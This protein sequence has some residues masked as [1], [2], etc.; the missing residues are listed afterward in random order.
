M[1]TIERH[2]HEHCAEPVDGRERSEQKTCPVLV[3]AGLDDE[4]VVGGL[5]R[6]TS[7]AAYEEHPEQVEEVELDKSM[8]AV[9]PFLAVSRTASMRRLKP[10]RRP[11]F[12]LAPTGTL[13]GEQRIEVARHRRSDDELDEEPRMTR[14]QSVQHERD[15]GLQHGKNHQNPCEAFRMQASS[16]EQPRRQKREQRA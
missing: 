1:E 16:R 14:R 3:V 2:R 10:S 5:Y 13:M 9:L 7:Y 8:P 11:A 12:A 6:E 15:D 4:E